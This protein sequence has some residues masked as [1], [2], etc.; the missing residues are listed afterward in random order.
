VY[1]SFQISTTHGLPDIFQVVATAKDPNNYEVK[2]YVV[3]DSILLASGKKSSNEDMDKSNNSD[4]FHC[5][6]IPSSFDEDESA[7]IKYLK[8]KPDPSLRYWDGVSFYKSGRTVNNACI[9]ADNYY[10]GNNKMHI[11]KQRSKIYKLV[12]FRQYNMAHLKY[13]PS[14]K[15]LMFDYSTDE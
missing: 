1:D 14:K 4:P 12:K 5:G 2:E 13:L 11:H 3:P 10:R 8:K 15:N 9:W 7:S 6:I